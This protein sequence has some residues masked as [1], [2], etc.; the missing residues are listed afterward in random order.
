MDR[1]TR[2]LVNINYAFFKT[3]MMAAPSWTMC[4]AMGKIA[5]ILF[6]LL[7]PTWYRKDGA[8]AQQGKTRSLVSFYI[9]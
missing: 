6:L 5:S 7:M 1:M 3:A 4:V 9:S 2:V 8:L